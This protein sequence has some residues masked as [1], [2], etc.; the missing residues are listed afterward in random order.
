MTAASIRN[1]KNTKSYIEACIKAIDMGCKANFVWYGVNDK[2]SDL[3]ENVKYTNECIKMVEEKG[4]ANRIK[5]LPKRKDIEKA[6]QE[7]DIFCLP[8]HFE[9]TPNVICE[10]IASGLP[11]MASNICD[12]P[13]FVIPGRNGWLFNQNDID[14]MASKILKASG[15]DCILLE[16]YG[17]ESRIIAVEKCSEAMFVDKYIKLIESL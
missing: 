11:I 14:D 17:K 10:A 8:S 13:N 12:N 15:A 4:L 6:Y 1:S 9:G 5:L 3:P 2:N 16:K 7:A